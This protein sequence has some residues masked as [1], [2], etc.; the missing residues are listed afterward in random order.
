MQKATFN[1]IEAE[2]YQYPNNPNTVKEIKND[3]FDL[4]HP[5]LEEIAIGTRRF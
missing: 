2:L 3:E 1:H 4:L 5:Y